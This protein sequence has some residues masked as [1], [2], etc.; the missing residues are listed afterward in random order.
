LIA[1]DVQKWKYRPLFACVF[2]SAAR[3]DG[4]DVSDIDLLLVRPSTKSEFD[5]KQK[6]SPALAVLE[7]GA[8]AFA[9]RVLRESQVEVWEKEVDAL[10]E[11]VQLWSGNPLQVINISALVW[12]DHRNKKS[13]I[14]RNI[15]NDGVPLYDELNSSPHPYVFPEE[16]SED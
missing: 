7:F 6:N 11:R 14:Y 15:T 10:H 12:S 1:R 8:T 3:H 4:D 2:G 9:S 5:E 13:E 16:G